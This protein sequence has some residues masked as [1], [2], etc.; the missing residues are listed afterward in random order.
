MKTLARKNR[1]FMKIS[2]E[3]DPCFQDDLRKKCSHTF[4]DNVV[5]GII[6][7]DE[8]GLISL[9]YPAAEILF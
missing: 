3:R 9:F 7:I 6:A 2:M 8:R 5:D 1:D 4:L